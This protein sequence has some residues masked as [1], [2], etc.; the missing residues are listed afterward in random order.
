MAGNLVDN[1]TLV[2]SNPTALTYSAGVISG[3]GTVIKRAA[4]TLTLSNGPETYSGVTS[5][6]AGTLQVGT[7]DVLSDGSPVTLPAGTTLDMNN[8]KD[9]IAALSGPGSVINNTSTTL[10][11]GGDANPGAVFQNYSCIYAVITNGS[12]AKDGT[13]AMALRETNGLTVPVTLKKGTLSVGI[14]PNQML[15]ATELDVP[16][17]AT[18]QLDANHQAVASLSGSGKLNLGGGTLTVNQTNDTTFSGVIQ[19]SDVAGSSTAVGH[20]LRGYYYDN[21]DFTSL[22]AVRDDASVNFT[23]L[24]VINDTNGLPS[25]FT[26]TNDFSIR[27]LGQVQ[28][29]VAGDYKFTSATDDGARL[30]VNGVL[31]VDSWVLQSPTPRSGMVTLAANTRY[32]V[33]FEYRSEERRVGKEC[34]SMCR[35]RWSPYH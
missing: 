2:F 30:W 9:T 8:K 25:V 19:N 31:V 33:V 5:I 17:E 29:T 32:D 3:T 24:S 4:G 27:W 10:T 11:L 22:L 20:G 15:A 6:E 28:S 14:R 34:A 35:S 13:H 18:F 12:L 16:L 21:I 1:A 7:D 26:S 23:N